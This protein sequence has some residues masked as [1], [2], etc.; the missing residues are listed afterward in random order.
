MAWFNRNKT[1]EITAETKTPIDATPYVPPAEE[2]IWVEGYKGTNKDMK[3]RDFQY[4]LHKQFDM[5]EDA[6]IEACSSGF[7]FSLTLTDVFDFYN[8][9][10]GNRF[11]KVEA[12]V[13]K[14]DYENY[15]N[16]GDSIARMSYLAG[17][18]DSYSIA[19]GHHRKLAAKSIILIEE[20]SI[21]TILKGTLVENS[22]GKYKAIAIETN[23]TTAIHQFGV[24]T[25]IED[26][27]SEA[28]ASYI[29]TQ[30]KFDIAHAAGTQKNLSMDMKVLTILLGGHK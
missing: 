1:A 5:P 8:I 30:N 4:E 10:F 18:R 12:L 16:S 29:V 27:Y 13:R 20:M 19:P 21:D 24:D 7:H 23:I 25:L 22:P 9:G 26:G 3:C 2:W 28:F 14:A 15:K 11:F 6:K 17:Y